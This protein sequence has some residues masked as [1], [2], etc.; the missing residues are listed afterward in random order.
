[1]Y[2][3]N[4]YNKACHRNGMHCSSPTSQASSFVVVVSIAN[5]DDDLCHNRQMLWHVWKVP[6][7]VP[8]RQHESRYDVKV[9]GARWVAVAGDVPLCHCFCMAGVQAMAAG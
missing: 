3:K 2:N 7:D 5:G 6:I 9:V 1:M 4:K 8:C